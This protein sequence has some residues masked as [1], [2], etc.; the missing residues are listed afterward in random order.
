MSINAR[1]TGS[2][3]LQQHAANGRPTWKKRF[4]CLDVFKFR[5]PTA[6]TVRAYVH[7]LVVA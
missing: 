3:V 2:L 5:R 7:N 6:T 1:E 4:E